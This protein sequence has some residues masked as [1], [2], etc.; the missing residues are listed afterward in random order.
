[1]YVLFLSAPYWLNI[2]SY[3]DIAIS[4]GGVF[5]AAALEDLKKL[6]WAASRFTPIPQ[7]GSRLAQTSMI[8]HT[9][10]DKQRDSRG[11]RWKN[12]CCF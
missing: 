3:F 10:K 1:M 2:A 9:K 12:R 7:A 6:G 5:L 4:P 8:E 11:S